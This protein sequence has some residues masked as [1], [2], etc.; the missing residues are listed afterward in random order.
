MS[1]IIIFLKYLR[2]LK[3]VLSYSFSDLLDILYGIP[4]GSILS[5]LFFNI[6]LCALLLSEYN[7]KFSNLW[8]SPFL[9]NV[10]ENN[11]KPI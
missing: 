1:F 3:W 8:M 10:K 5:P 7:F 4:H 2:K 9:I 6:N 11:E